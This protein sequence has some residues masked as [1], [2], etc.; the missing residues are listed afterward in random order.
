MLTLDNVETTDQFEDCQ[1]GPIDNAVGALVDVWNN[2]VRLQIAKGTGTQIEWLPAPY[3]RLRSPTQGLTII[4]CRGIRFK[5][6]VPGSP[7]RIVADLY[8]PGD[9]PFSGGTPNEQ[10][11]SS[12]GQAISSNMITGIVAA[13]GT[14]TAGSGFSVNRT[15]AGIYVITFTSPFSAAPVVVANLL[16]DTSGHFVRVRTVTTSGFTLEV[17]GTDFG[18]PGIDTAFDFIATAVQ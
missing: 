6:A 1:L 18:Q 3:G 12:A 9:P 17:R 5:S 7:A 4:G 14:I 11:L 8:L 16:D 13:N 10:I 2:S 15:A